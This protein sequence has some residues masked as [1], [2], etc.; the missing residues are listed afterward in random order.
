MNMQTDDKI[1]TLRDH[2]KDWIGSE[3][4]DAHYFETRG[5]SEAVKVIND[6][7]AAFRRELAGVDAL[8]EAAARRNREAKHA[9]ALDTWTEEPGIMLRIESMPYGA[10]LAFVRNGTVVLAT[11]S[12]HFDWRGWRLHSSPSWR[13][14]NRHREVPGTNAAPRRRRTG[15]EYHDSRP[16]PGDHR[17][18]LSSARIREN[19]RG[20]FLHSM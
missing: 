9:K 7:I 3:E 17:E 6:R 19:G 5:D 18:P 4:E 13:A 12:H 11:G 15:D 1:P 10:A 20:A 8:L 16:V 14:T 2:M